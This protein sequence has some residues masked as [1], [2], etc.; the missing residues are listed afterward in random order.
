ML[1]A[2]E[3]FARRYLTW[4]AHDESVPWALLLAMRADLGPTNE[5]V[6]IP[7]HVR[8]PAFRTRGGDA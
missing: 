5:P 1:L 8:Q 7:I 2:L 4:R 3:D 6:E